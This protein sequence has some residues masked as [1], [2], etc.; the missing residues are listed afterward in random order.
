LSA[1]ETDK[2]VNV[3]HA[4]ASVNNDISVDITHEN[5]INHDD[6]KQQSSPNPQLSRSRT[7]TTDVPNYP[8]SLT[9]S[10]TAIGSTF[11]NSRLRSQTNAPISPNAN[12]IRKAV[13]VRSPKD[14]SVLMPVNSMD[15]QGLSNILRK[16]NNN[17]ETNNSTT[18]MFKKFNRANSSNLRDSPRIWESRLVDCPEHIY[19]YIISFLDVKSVVTLSILCKFTYITGRSK[20]VWRQ[21]VRR[22]LKNYVQKKDTLHNLFHKEK[23]MI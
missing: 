10:R 7:A 4:Q 19:F 15:P 12:V 16:W 6:N 13:L 23:E 14:P 8:S 17:N 20:V 9:R 18:S 3:V 5:N 11:S 2:Q 1:P 21:L 22:D